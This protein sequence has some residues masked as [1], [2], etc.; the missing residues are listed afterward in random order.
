MEPTERAG[1][2]VRLLPRGV[3]AR[4]AARATASSVSLVGVYFLAPLDGTA[5]GT[6]VAFVAGLVAVVVLV[7]RQVRAVLTAPYPL[8]RSIEALAIIMPL[9]VVLWSVAFVV[10]SRSDPSA[11]SEPLDRTGALYLTVSVLATV[12]F[13]D[14]VAVTD[15]ARA[16]V[17][18]Q[19]VGNLV[20]VGVVV[21][22]FVGAAQ[23]GRSMRDVEG[24]ERHEPR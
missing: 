4:V 16:L 2:S 23:L 13:G 14:V 1:T 9:Y 5:T 18:V 24:H 20:V 7:G 11:F 17:T 3:V 15:W 8:L 19:M 6:A 21:R 12:G 22:L 10:L